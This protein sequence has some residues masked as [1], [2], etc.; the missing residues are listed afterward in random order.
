MDSR[1]IEHEH[2]IRLQLFGQDQMVTGEGSQTKVMMG[3]HQ[4]CVAHRLEQKLYLVKFLLIRYLRIAKVEVAV[5][6]L[7]SQAKLHLMLY[8]S[9]RKSS[10]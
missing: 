2:E 8:Y 5:Y 9:Y 1:P 7:N 3:L 10:L 6:R 4:S